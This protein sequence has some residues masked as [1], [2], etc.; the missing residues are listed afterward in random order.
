[1]GQ[2]FNQDHSTAWHGIKQFDAF[3][4]QNFF[5]EYLNLYNDLHATMQKN[6]SPELLNF[7]LN[8]AVKDILK[9]KDIDVQF[10][11]ESIEKLQELI[12]NK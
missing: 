6:K 9:S 4:H 10:I 8:S 11:K 3:K 12:K 1:M 5:K 7:Y 2:L